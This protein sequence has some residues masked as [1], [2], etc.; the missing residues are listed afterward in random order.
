VNLRD[1][2]MPA[3]DVIRAVTGPA[4][5]WS[6]TE[7]RRSA[8]GRARTGAIADVGSAGFASG[9]ERAGILLRQVVLLSGLL[10]LLNQ[11]LVHQMP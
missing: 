10:R 2:G 6:D 1:A 9:Y 11:L 8:A 7:Q 4:S 3:P 5:L